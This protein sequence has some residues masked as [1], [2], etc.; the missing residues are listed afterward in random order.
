MEQDGHA[1]DKLDLV[2]AR[3]P[4]YRAEAYAFVVEALRFTLER[5]SRTGHV[6]AAELM[7][8]IRDFGIREFGPLT[9]TVFNHWGIH[10]ASQFGD[11]VYN[12]IAVQ[13]LGKRPEDQREDF[14]RASFDLDSLPTDGSP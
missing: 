12:M 11:L 7:A 14:D 3:D 1:L 4:R 5:A 10:H 13:L 8:G 2:L 9:K 6:S